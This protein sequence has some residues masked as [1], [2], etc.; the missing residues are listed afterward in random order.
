MKLL[1]IQNAIL[2]DKSLRKIKAIYDEIKDVLKHENNNMYNLEL[3]EIS[4]M[5]AKDLEQNILMYENII[6]ICKIAQKSM[7][8]DFETKCTIFRIIMS[9]ICNTLTDEE[10]KRDDIKFIKKL[11]SEIIDYDPDK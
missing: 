9:C 2:S 3:F 7:G 11:C 10:N 5:R 8:R 6:K 4:F 1:P